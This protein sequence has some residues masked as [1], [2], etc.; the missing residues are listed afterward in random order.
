MAD[1]R[2]SATSPG[3]TVGIDAVGLGRGGGQT[4]LRELLSGGAPAEHG[5]H[6][7]VVWL[8]ARMV[9]SFEAPWLEIRRI[10][11]MDAP[12]RRV[13]LWQKRLG[14]NEA[15]AAQCDVLFVPLGYYL[16]GFHPFV[17]LFQNLLPF[18]PAERR[19][20]GVTPMRLRLHLLEWLHRRSYPRAD[21]L[22]FLTHAAQQAVQNRMKMNFPHTAIVPHGIAPRFFRAPARQPDLTAFSAARPFRW[23]YVSTVDLYKHQWHVARAVAQ[24]RGQGLPV[25]LELVGPA[26]PPALRRLDRTLHEV[27]PAREFIFYRR[28]LPY[29]QLPGVYHQADGFVFAS[30]C[31][32]LPNILI[33]AMAAG[34]PIAC[35]HHA[36]VPEVLQ[37]AGEYFDPEQP[38]DIAA[39]LRRLMSDAARRQACADGAYR[40]AGHYSWQ[41]CSRDTFGFLA[42]VAREFSRRRR[43]MRVDR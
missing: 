24:L 41:R 10:P 38:S 39:A 16:G 26:Y 19:R 15:W 18:S 36:P 7:V 8:G 14:V 30:S 43:Q 4:H 27:D 3:I 32:N 13:F 31:E 2:T 28:P 20:Y 11:D 40:L 25:T 12:V 17:T 42:A 33:E 21:G 35:S 37:D 23:L 29:D 9:F 22:I 1:A 6:R 34:L 5:I